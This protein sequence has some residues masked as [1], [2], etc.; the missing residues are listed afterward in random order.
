MR[1]SLSALII[2]AA[3]LLPGCQTLGAAEPE[4]YAVD[5]GRLPAADVALTI[6]GLRPC[7]DHPDTTLRLSSAHPLAVLVHGRSGSSGLLH[8][9]AQGLALHG[10]QAACF[11]YNDRDSLTESSAR[12]ASSLDLLM[13]YT[14]NR[15]VT[16]IGHSQGALLARRS[17]AADHPQPLRSADVRVRLVTVAGPFGGIASASHCGLPIVRVLTLGLVVPICQIILG[18]K[19]T[20]I[21]DGADFIRRPGR[22]QPQVVQHL[23]INTDERGSCR[24]DADG[25][26]VKEDFIFTLEEQRHPFVDHDGVTKV[27]ELKAG[28]VEIIGDSNLS[29]AKLITALRQNG[30]FESEAARTDTAAAAAAVSPHGISSS[31]SGASGASGVDF[32][33]G[34]K[35]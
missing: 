16:V 21:T 19:W 34:P 25:S 22:L 24:S 30:V 6:P 35:H 4:A 20:E 11:T 33:A 29:P 14:T 5:A 31:V 2:S 7:T 8:G 9:L 10:R 18:D 3:T 23:K 1:R 26:C 27:V 13:Q 17:L 28:H 15:H 32:S 12:L